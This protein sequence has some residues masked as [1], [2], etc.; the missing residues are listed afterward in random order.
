M[1]EYIKQVLPRI[2]NASKNLDHME[3]FVEKP[4][5]MLKDGSEEH[6]EYEFYRDGRLLVSNGGEV[7]WG[8]WELTP[9]SQ[10]L[11]L[12][13][14]G[15]S[16]LIRHAF[17]DDALM[18]IKLSGNPNPSMVFVNSQKIPDLNYQ[19]Y[20]EEMIRKTEEA[21][22]K[23]I[24]AE[25]AKNAQRDVPR[26]HIKI[27]STTVNQDDQRTKRRIAQLEKNVQASKPLVIQLWDWFTA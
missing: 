13:Y 2:Q 14:G 25:K 24:E 19:L 23:M 4:W 17:I 1:I 5:V 9:S 11:I 20:L 22:Q 12:T 10:K 7:T 3:V 18:I 26:D 16:L 27:N 15:K 8:T 6:L 21:A